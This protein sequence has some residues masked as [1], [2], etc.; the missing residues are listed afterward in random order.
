MNGQYL[1]IKKAIWIVW[2]IYSIFISIVILALFIFN[3]QFLIAL[4]P[5]CESIRRF[6]VECSICGMTRAFIEIS[7]GDMI[8]AI[9]LNKGSIGLFVVFLINTL[10]FIILIIRKVL[11]FY[12]K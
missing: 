8:Q 9:R 12:K 6:G 4:S 3:G 5:H 2:V 1:E 7:N 10:I 11:G